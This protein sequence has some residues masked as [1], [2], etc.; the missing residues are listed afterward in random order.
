MN[1]FP[2]KVAGKKMCCFKVFPDLKVTVQK[3]GQVINTTKK[4]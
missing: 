4:N 1:Y 3:R 2:E